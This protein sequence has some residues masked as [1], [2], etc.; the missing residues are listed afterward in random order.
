MVSSMNSR[1]PDGLDLRALDLHHDDCRH[2]I[3]DGTVDLEYVAP[4]LGLHRD[5]RVVRE[6]IGTR[7]GVLHGRQRERRAWL[8][9]EREVQLTRLCRHSPL[10]LLVY[11]GVAAHVPGAARA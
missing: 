7:Q 3:E 8:V 10:V 4:V 5:R 1:S 11:E 9:E 2:R 6:A